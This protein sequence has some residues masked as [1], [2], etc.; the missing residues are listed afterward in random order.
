MQFKLFLVAVLSASSALSMTV[1]ASRR[2]ASEA[3]PDYELDPHKRSVFVSDTNY[4]LDPSDGIEASEPVVVDQ[5]SVFG[6]TADYELDPSD[7]IE[8][9]VTN[10]RSVFGCA[11]DYEIDPRDDKVDITQRSVC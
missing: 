6:V 5:R 7:E 4:E 1:P 3:S 8:P 2:S 9:A 10:K 11:A